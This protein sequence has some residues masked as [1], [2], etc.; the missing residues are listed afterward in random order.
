[1]QSGSNLYTVYIYN[2]R[3]GSSWFILTIR[4]NMVTEK[5]FHSS[6]AEAIYKALSFLQKWLDL[7]KLSDRSKVRGRDHGDHLELAKQF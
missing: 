5:R 6:P 2:F 1:M 4:N 7:L 3:T